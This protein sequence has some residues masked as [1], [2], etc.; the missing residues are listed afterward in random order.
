MKTNLI[1]SAMLAMASFL[2]A[3]GDDATSHY[4]SGGIAYL[5]GMNPY[6]SSNPADYI[7]DLLINVLLILDLWKV[8][9]QK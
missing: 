7:N 5:S 6:Y 9:K 4:I 1:Y 3:C 2:G 8:I